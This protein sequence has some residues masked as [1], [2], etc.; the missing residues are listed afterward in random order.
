MDQ[1]S[2]APSPSSTSD[3][4][5]P[6][7]SHAGVTSRLVVGV[8][9]DEVEARVVLVRKLLTRLSRSLSDDVELSD[10]TSRL[11]R[12]LQSTWDI[13]L[14]PLMPGASGRAANRFA[15]ATQERLHVVEA[16]FK[17]IS[18]EVVD[19]M[20]ASEMEDR[21]TKLQR[22]TRQLEAMQQ[23][24]SATNKAKVMEALSGAW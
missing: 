3:V 20:A 14:A 13:K 22:T 17:K 10:D 11:F 1:Q 5:T 8:D 12:Q 7:T 9:D 18:R 19:A 21:L 6:P 24:P 16:E 15:A 2:G 23:Q 4:A